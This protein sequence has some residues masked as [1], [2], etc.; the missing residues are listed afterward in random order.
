MLQTSWPALA[1]LF[2]LVL[3]LALFALT[4]AQ[5]F[6]VEQR[7]KVLRSGFVTAIIWGT[8]LTALLSVL[9]AVLFAARAVPWPPAVIST[10]CALLVAPLLLQRLP[11]S[12]VNGRRGLLVFAGLAVVLAS[13]AMHM[14]A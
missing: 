12:L 4:A 5:H 10:G 8:L 14:T 1:L 7:A 6:P 13:V 2:A 3:T 9:I 11:D